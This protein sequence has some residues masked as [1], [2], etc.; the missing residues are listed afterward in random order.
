M[1]NRVPRTMKIFEN[2]MCKLM[3][4][5]PVSGHFQHESFWPWVVSAHFICESFLPAIF[6]GGS[7]RP[8]IPPPPIFYI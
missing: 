2:A 7:F 5:V 3:I 4:R 6:L 1:H 8:D